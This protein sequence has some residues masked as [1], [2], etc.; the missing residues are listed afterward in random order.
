[1]NVR[2]LILFILGALTTVFAMNYTQALKTLDLDPPSHFL[3]TQANVLRQ[4]ER[5]IKNLYASSSTRD[6]PV[7]ALN[8]VA[9]LKDARNTLIKLSNEG[10]HGY[11]YVYV[12]AAVGAIITVG[13]FV[14]EVFT[15]TKGLVS[16]NEPKLSSLGNHKGI[17]ELV[18]QQVAQ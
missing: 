3:R 14:H 6:D 12:G 7:A 1:M 18:Q 4:Y 16:G 15:T 13:W 10:T 5:K 17:R 8:T 2:T 9:K 11:Q